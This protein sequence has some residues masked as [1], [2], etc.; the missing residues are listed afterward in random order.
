MSKVNKFES[1][2]MNIK[3]EI[4]DDGYF[5]CVVVKIIGLFFSKYIV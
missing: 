2:I 4:V 1:Y 3:N 5:V